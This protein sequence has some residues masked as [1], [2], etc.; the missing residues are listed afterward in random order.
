MGA[1]GLGVLLAVA[2]LQ[3]VDADACKA[4]RCRSVTRS[5]QVGGWVPPAIQQVLNTGLVRA[6]LP[7]VRT[8]WHPLAGAR[9]WCGHGLACLPVSLGGA[10]QRLLTKLP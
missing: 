10:T 3:R 1:Q 4:S 5:L 2:S 6:T 8:H 9:S 7:L